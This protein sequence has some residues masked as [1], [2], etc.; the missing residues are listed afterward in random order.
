M[1]IKKNVNKI[2]KFLYNQ[3]KMKEII[4]KWHSYG[5]GLEILNGHLAKMDL[6]N[7]ARKYMAINKLTRP[8]K[9]RIQRDG[10]DKFI[11]Q[12]KRLDLLNKL[13]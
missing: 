7:R 8:I 1:K 9:H 10:W 11:L 5:L 6:L 12:L 13:R 3:R 4:E 2:A